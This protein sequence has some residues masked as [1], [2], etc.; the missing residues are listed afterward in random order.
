MG[1]KLVILLPSCD[2]GQAISLLHAQRAFYLSPLSGLL[3]SKGVNRE[4]SGHKKV[5][6]AWLHLPQLPEES[7]V[8][9]SHTAC[10]E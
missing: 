2:P 3:S 6:T 4:E 1:S 5:G 9:C 8:C 7:G 10:W